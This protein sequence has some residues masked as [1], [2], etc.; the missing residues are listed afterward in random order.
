M[1]WTSLLVSTNESGSTNLYVAKIII[2]DINNHDG[3]TRADYYLTVTARNFHDPTGL[4]EMIQKKQA[5]QT[6]PFASKFNSFI[7]KSLLG[8]ISLYHSLGNKFGV[9]W[10]SNND[11]GGHRDINIGNDCTP[12]LQQNHQESTNHVRTSPSCLRHRH[13]SSDGYTRIP[14]ADF[15]E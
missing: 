12:D 11:V 15:D 10:G 1:L 6:V 7:E 9:S 2:D 3:I 14:S 5:P 8:R 13:G 4:I